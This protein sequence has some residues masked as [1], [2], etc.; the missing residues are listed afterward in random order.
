MITS[1]LLQRVTSHRKIAKSIK[2]IVH[3]DGAIETKSIPLF[4]GREYSN[5]TKMIMPKSLWGFI[6]TDGKG[7]VDVAAVVDIWTIAENR[8]SIEVARMDA[9]EQ[10]VII[11]ITGERHVF[12]AVGG[13]PP[14]EAVG[15]FYTEVT[16]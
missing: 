6:F 2:V 8:Y 4:A 1:R 16:L 10:E 11:D 3:A 13:A 14:Q 15:Y 12:P 5:L 7:N 9:A